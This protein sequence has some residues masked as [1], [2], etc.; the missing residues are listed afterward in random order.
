MPKQLV[1]FSSVRRVNKMK[2]VGLVVEYNP[3]HNGHCY[4]LQKA[5]ELTGAD[6]VIAVMSGNFTQRGEPT[7]VDKWHRTEAALKNGIDLVVELPLVNAVEPAD[8]FATGALRLLADLQ[9]DSVVF[10]AEHPQWDFEKMV[11]LEDH[12]STEQFKQFDQTY[13]TQF[14]TQLHEQLGIS[15]IDPNDILAFS[16]TKAKLKNNLKVNLVPLARRNSQYH[17]QKITGKIASASA[18]RY[19]VQEQKWE[20]L[21]KTVPDSTFKQLHAQSRVPSWESLYPILRNELIQAPS[22]RLANIYQMSEGLENRLK[23]A[24]Q[25]HLTFTEFIK[26]AKTKRYT[27]AHLSRLLL[28]VVLQATTSQVNTAVHNPYH[29]VLG[30]TARGR[31]YLHEVKKQLEYPL[32]VKVDQTLDS[33]RLDLDYRAGKLYQNFTPIEQDLKHSPLRLEVSSKNR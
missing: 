17:D 18:I 19:A 20:L 2:A 5:R 9:V 30:F 8:R 10:G 23:R 11:A 13:A 31:Q 15:L 28:Y 4:H 14:N 27:Y 3:F 7:I 22:S 25:H 26:E 29:H 21:K 1:G 12:F 33:G 16:Y 24:A 32:I 6:V